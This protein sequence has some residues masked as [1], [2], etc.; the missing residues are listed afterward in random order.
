MVRYSHFLKNFPV[1][2]DSHKVFRVVNEAEIVF[3]FFFMEFLCFFY[4]LANAGYLISG[5]FT[6]SKA[7][8]TSG[9]YGFFFFF[10]FFNVFICFLL[11]LSLFDILI[12]KVFSQTITLKLGYKCMT[13]KCMNNKKKSVYFKVRLKAVTV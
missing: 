2:C 13:K 10:F 1:C 7:A 9:S 3:F 6:S 5:S 8:F 4:D 11:S 12:D